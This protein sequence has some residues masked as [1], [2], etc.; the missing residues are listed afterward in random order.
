MGYRNVTVSKPHLFPAC[1]VNC[2][3]VEL[4]GRWFVD[5]GFEINHL[6]DAFPDGAVY[7][8]EI[9]V[10]EYVRKFMDIIEEQTRGLEDLSFGRPRTDP[11]FDG[12]RETLDAI[13]QR[14]VENGS[15]S[16]SKQ[17]D[18]FSASFGG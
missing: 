14:T 16:E 2:G 1:C 4:S 8:C 3:A 10:R 17:D 12:Y 11:V 7:M 6:Y 9:C 5:L 13:E 15:D 18:T